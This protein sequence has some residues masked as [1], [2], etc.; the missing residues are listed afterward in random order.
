MLLKLIIFSVVAAVV[1]RFFGG[2]LPFIDKKSSSDE[3]HDFGKI[4]TTSECAYC[5]TYMT[6]E[7]ALIY[8][9][10]AYC[11]AECLEKSKKS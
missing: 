6:E 11:S 7:D 5:S 3:K 4:E 1:F 10:H 2:K 9:K 8:Q